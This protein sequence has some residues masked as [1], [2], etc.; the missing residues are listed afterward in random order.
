MGA[1]SSSSSDVSDGEVGS[2]SDV[3][4]RVGTVCAEGFCPGA[5]QLSD[6]P[7]PHKSP[8]LSPS[9]LSKTITANRDSNLISGDR[10]MTTNLLSAQG[11]RYE[12]SIF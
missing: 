7:P 2:G 1:V 5:A 4:G 8:A 11:K 10:F 6:C 9:T 3:G 12:T